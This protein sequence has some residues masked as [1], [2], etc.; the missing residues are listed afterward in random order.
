MQMLYEQ[1]ADLGY[2]NWR[3]SEPI[4]QLKDVNDIQKMKNDLPVSLCPHLIVSAC[5]RH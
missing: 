5:D 4:K 1:D 3:Q 2:N